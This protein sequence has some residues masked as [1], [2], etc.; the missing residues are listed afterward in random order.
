MVKNMEKHGKTW[1]KTWLKTWLKTWKNMEKTWKNMEKPHHLHFLPFSVHPFLPRE[2]PFF[3][4][5]LVFP[6]HPEP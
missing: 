1:K 3:G 6:G 4:F 5:S 2:T